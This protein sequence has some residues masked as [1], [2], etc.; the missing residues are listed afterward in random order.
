MSLQPSI[1]IN[2][3]ESFERAPII[4]PKQQQQQQQQQQVHRA[5][6]SAAIVNT[7]NSNTKELTRAKPALLVT[8]GNRIVDEEKTEP[9]V[10]TPKKKTP[11]GSSVSPPLSPSD[12]QATKKGSKTLLVKSEEKTKV[13]H[14]NR[15]KSEKVRRSQP[16]SPVKTTPTKT[17]PAAM[18][19]PEKGKT[20]TKEAT[21]ST[22]HQQNKTPQAHNV[23]VSSSPAPSASTNNTPVKT[24]T[25]PAANENTS[26]VAESKEV[27][28]PQKPSPAVSPDP[29]EFVIID[30]PVP[31]SDDAVDEA[32]PVEVP[33]S[34]YFP[35]AHVILNSTD[36][37]LT[38]VNV[39]MCVMIYSFQPSR[40]N[41]AIKVCKNYCV[42]T[43]ICI[44]Y[45]ITNFQEIF[46]VVTK[47]W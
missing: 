18:V 42:H 17:D 2:T 11:D 5:S 3:Q 28:K 33:V 45:H 29:D 20:P 6:E 31:S 8:I 10:T 32:I 22:D 12:V 40:P 7:G 47:M 16:T 26:T 37:S 35:V 4:P 36:W 38:I 25:Q 43:Y 15:A 30:M 39:G 14:V 46:Y 34:E 9:A 19:T 13:S 24:E 21:P 23:K 44:V 41:T 27:E 1:V